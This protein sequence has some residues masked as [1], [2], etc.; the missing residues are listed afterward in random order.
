[1]IKRNIPMDEY[2]AMSGL[3]KHELDNFAVAPSYYKFR[4]GQEWRPSRS[5]EMGTLIHSLVLEGRKDYAVGPMVD[6]R[7]KLGKEEWQL[8]C[9]DNIGK[10]IITMDEEAT[11]LGCQKACEPLLEHCIHR[12]G[13]I[14]TS[15]FWERA[16]INCKG[17][18][19]MLCHINGEPA[20]LDLKTTAD[21]R[22]FDNKFFSFRYDVQAAWY[23]RG[24][25]QAAGLK[26]APAFWFLAVDTEAP[27]L[28]QLIRASTDLLQQA[29]DKIDEELE[30]FMECV[31]EDFWPSLPKFRV[32]LPRTQW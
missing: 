5:M 7:T 25:Q 16:G 2:R 31:N 18:P 12:E 26:D 14:E 9:E 4:L 11:I 30:R 6:R 8:F 13:D 21:I 29:N 28:A 17:R 3:S 32:M 19:D 24:F 22:T 20:L 27:H 15:M 10:T 23:Q 1:M